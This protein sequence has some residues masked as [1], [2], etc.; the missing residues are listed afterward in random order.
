MDEDLKALFVEQ[1]NAERHAAPAWSPLSLHAPASGARSRGALVVG[2]VAAVLAV[3][4]CFL[5]L[6]P[7]EPRMTDLPSLITPEHDHLFTTL[8]TPSTDCLLPPHLTIW[9]P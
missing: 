8:D 3:V 4:G 2:A 6:E 9:M 7:G 5:F 1:R